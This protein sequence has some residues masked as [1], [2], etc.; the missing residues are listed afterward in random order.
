MTPQSLLAHAFELMQLALLVI[1]FFAIY[2]LRAGERRLSRMYRASGP[3]HR[4]RQPFAWFLLLS[5]AILVFTRDM[6]PLRAALLRG[7]P[8]PSIDQS[9]AIAL[10]FTLDLLGA[11][12]LVAYTGGYARSPFTP[13]LLLL[14]VLAILLRQT[15]LRVTAYAAGAAL[16]IALLVRVP[17]VEIEVNPLQ[18][19]A[20]VVVTW[21]CLALCVLLGY[22]M[23]LPL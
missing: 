3:A 6:L 10:V 21:G 18:R 8:L 4:L 5:L 11:A 14:P 12:V 2:T 20:S 22:L 7:V 19:Q 17:E 13:I 15:P 23:R 9:L 1:V 16:L